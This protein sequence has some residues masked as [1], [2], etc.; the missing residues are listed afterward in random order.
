MAVNVAGNVISRK[1]L[2]PSKAPSPMA[3][4]VTGNTRI[5]RC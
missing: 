1:L 4:T 3:V 2:H 5:D